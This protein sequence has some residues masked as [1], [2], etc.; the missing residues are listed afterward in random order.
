MSAFG[1]EVPQGDPGAL[2]A[3]A[4]EWRAL[5]VA[6]DLQGQAAGAASQVA[7]GAGSWEG[8]A[9]SAFAGRVE[10]LIG[11]MRS[12]VNACATAASALS[13]LAQALENAQ[14]I[15]RQALA[16][17]E[18]AQS[19]A[20]SQQSAA[21]SA[22][23]SAQAA[24]QA[25]ASAVHPTAVKQFSDQ[26]SQARSQQ[27]QAQAA[28][29]QARSALSAAQARGQHAVQA[30]HQEAE[31][32]A[33]RLRSAT[34]ELKPTADLGHGWAEPVVTWAGHANDFLGAGAVGVIKGYDSAIDL[35]MKSLSSDLK[36]VL[37]DSNMI[38]QVLTNNTIAGV[39]DV[40]DPLFGRAQGALA[41]SQNPLIKFLTKGLPEKAGPLSEV[42]YLAVALSALDVGLNWKDQGAR[43]LVAPAGNLAAATIITHYAAPTAARLAYG[44]TD[45]A[46]SGAEFLGADGLATTLAGSAL[47]PGVGEAVVVGGVVVV[48]TYY[49][50][51]GVVWV[52]DHGGAHV[53]SE[54]WHGIEQGASGAWHGIEHGADWAWH[55]GGSLVQTGEHVVHD[56]EPWNWSL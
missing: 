24:E 11:A 55:E 13:Q 6:F 32:L 15:T 49:L 50:D 19:T 2:D 47:I 26:A 12:N 10:S 30:Y 37:G 35:A 36:T 27:S 33:G 8:Q 40:Q 29:D 56:L 3:A 38:A 9:A 42:P 20:N 17:C 31:S 1:F 51:K 28:A 43:S 53:A 46:A 41:L 22:G 7:L 54:A 45:L 21:D 5:G 39:T 23:A 52:W 25:A 44:A 16:E 18:S 4:A 48:G 14:R 34:G